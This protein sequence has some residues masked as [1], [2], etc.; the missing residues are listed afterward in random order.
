[1]RKQRQELKEKVLLFSG[2][3]R[4]RERE[5][6]VRAVVVT[7]RAFQGLSGWS[8]AAECGGAQ[9]RSAA[10]ECSRGVW[11]SAVGGA[12]R[13]PPPP[14][15]GLHVH[16]CALPGLGLSRTRSGPSVSSGPRPCRFWIP[17]LASLRSVRFGHASLPDPFRGEV[18]Y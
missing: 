14:M 9:Q 5:R 3:E 4:E 6:A 1:M 2:R 10:E 18:H 8:A 7:W 16:S 11:Q 13:P 15:H 17:P 12:R